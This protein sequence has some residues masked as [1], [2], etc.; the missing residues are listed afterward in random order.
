ATKAGAPEKFHVT[1]TLAFLSVIAERM[2][3][4][5]WTDFETFIAENE[6]LMRR[7]FLRAWYSDERLNTQRAREL[8]V[9]PRA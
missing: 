9:L 4:R 7:D 3:E 5:S 6:D 1:I 2:A 8:F